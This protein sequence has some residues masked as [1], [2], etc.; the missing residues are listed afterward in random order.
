[1]HLEC[2]SKRHVYKEIINKAVR[3]SSDNEFSEM[4]LQQ[5]L[6]FEVR[7]STNAVNQYVTSQRELK[8]GVGQ[9]AIAAVHQYGPGNPPAT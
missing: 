8:S 1:M 7:Q 5:I 9:P 3:Q 2:F 6:Q 4:S